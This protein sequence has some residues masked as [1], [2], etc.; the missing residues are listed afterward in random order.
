MG[1]GENAA[2]CEICDFSLSLCY[3]IFRCEKNSQQT[4]L[5]VLLGSGSI[6]TLKF[7]KKLAASCKLLPTQDMMVMNSR[8]SDDD[9]DVN[10]QL[11]KRLTEASIK[12]RTKI[13]A[14]SPSQILLLLLH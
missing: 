5:Q 12:A 11:R 2:K 1:G 8:I 4:K 3:M 13:P 7:K 10:A 6:C 14:K 9:N